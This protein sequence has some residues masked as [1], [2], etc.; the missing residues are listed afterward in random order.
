MLSDKMYDDK[1]YTTKS[2]P[3]KWN[4]L[5]SMVQKWGV[6]N[7]CNLKTDQSYVG[8]EQYQLVIPFPLR[9]VFCQ[10]TILSVSHFADINFVI[11]PY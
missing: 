11:V 7:Y 1:R 4:F 3:N 9:L 6:R 2:I 5:A 10:L 8:H